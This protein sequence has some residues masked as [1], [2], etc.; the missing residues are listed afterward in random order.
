[1]I[2]L[3]W[4]LVTLF[5]GRKGA[6]VWIENPLFPLWAAIIT[7]YTGI[8]WLHTHAHKNK[9][10]RIDKGGKQQKETLEVFAEKFPNFYVAEG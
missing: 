9:K 7:F 2:K 4:C 10:I 1:M 8:G 6:P 5:Q 3:V